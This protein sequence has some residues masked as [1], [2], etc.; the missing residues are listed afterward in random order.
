MTP[1]TIVQNAIH[2]SV[3]MDLTPEGSIRLNGSKSAVTRWAPTIRE[4]K[5]EL[6]GLLAANSTIG[7]QGA[8]AQETG[9]RAPK[10]DSDTLSDE[11]MERRR[12]AVLRLLRESPEITRA[13]VADGDLDPVRV[14]L[15]V[16]GIGT[17]E[18]TIAADKW[19]PLQFAALMDRQCNRSGTS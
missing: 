2:D 15:A 12:Q 7:A 18:L 13:T 1:E 3:V 16:R 9:E 4:H 17:C 8:H 11:A 6:V 14:A 10:Q 5:S 19:D